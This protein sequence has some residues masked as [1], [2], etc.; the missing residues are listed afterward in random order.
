MKNVAFL[1]PMRCGKDSIATYLV[2]SH[3]YKRLAFADNLKWEIAEIMQMM[4]NKQWTLEDIDLNKTRFRMGL[5]WW[6]TEIR[7]FDNPN[8]WIDQ[9]EMQIQTNLQTEN[10]SL[11]VTDTRFLNEIQMLEKYDFTF[12]RIEPDEGL[13]IG[14]KGLD[15]VSEQEWKS[16][17]TPHVVKNRYGY[18]GDFIRGVREI[19]EIENPVL[20][21]A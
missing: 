2:N 4:T 8:Y 1:G 20:Q 5:Q 12:I 15:H 11:V 6:G 16:Y 21:V 10:S 7:R 19:L 17:S 13:L 3:R 9:V 14:A 18:F